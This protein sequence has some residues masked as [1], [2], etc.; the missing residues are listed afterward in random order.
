MYSIRYPFDFP[1][2]SSLVLIHIDIDLVTT[3]SN[4]RVMSFR[5]HQCT[6]PSALIVV[7][8]LLFPVTTV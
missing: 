3:G 2:L 7:L 1:H 6:C 4:E 8:G 5:I